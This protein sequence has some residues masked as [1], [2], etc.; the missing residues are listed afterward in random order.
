MI[1]VLS[2]GDLENLGLVKE[3]KRIREGMVQGR[4]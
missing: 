2:L 4:S 3:N 1:V